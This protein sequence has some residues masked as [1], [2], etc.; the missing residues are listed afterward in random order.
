MYTLLDSTLTPQLPQTLRLNSVHRIHT[1]LQYLCFLLR[2]T[3]GTSEYE[4]TAP[5]EPLEKY[6]SGGLHPIHI[7][8]C[9]E[10]G[11]YEVLNKLGFGSYSTVWLA[12][13]NK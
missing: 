13:D 4:S 10:D 7:H 11:R 3:M 6:R 5:A 2:I 9:F 12:R 8:D 1:R